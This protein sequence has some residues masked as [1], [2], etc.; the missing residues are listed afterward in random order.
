MEYMDHED[1]PYLRMS[2]VVIM[3]S[4]W[5]RSKS[6]LL[7]PPKTLHAPLIHNH[8]IPSILSFDDW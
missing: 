5:T 7:L 2:P 1:E 3:N 8:F 6:I 4:R